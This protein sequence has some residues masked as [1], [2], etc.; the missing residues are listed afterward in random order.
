MHVHLYNFVNLHYMLTIA[1]KTFSSRLFTGTGKFSSN[2]IMRDALLASRSELVTVALKRI[3]LKNQDDDIL[4][5][6]NHIQFN[7]CAYICKYFGFHNGGVNR[8]INNF[9]GSF[10]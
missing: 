1:N 6:L 3:D 10:F 7:L 2:E 8:R 5:Y 4:R 9:G